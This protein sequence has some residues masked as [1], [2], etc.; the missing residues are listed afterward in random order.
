VRYDL[1]AADDLAPGELRAVQLDNL[2]IVVVRLLSGR[3][4]AMRDTCPHRGARL[5]RGTL[6]RM[7]VGDE[8]GAYRLSDQ[9]VIRCP[10]HGH[11]IDTETGRCVAPGG[12]IRVRTY[13][14]AVENG[15]VTLERPGMSMRDEITG[16]GRTAPP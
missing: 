9:L 7:V 12:A 10:W 5:S 3:F 16:A 8:V 15:R 13:E 4:E 2:A 11:E 14:I 6:Q 1:F